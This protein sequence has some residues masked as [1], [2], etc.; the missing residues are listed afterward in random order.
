M[1]TNRPGFE[2]K[3][4][5]LE[6]LLCRLAEYAETQ[7]LDAVKALKTDNLELARRVDRFES[8]INSLRFEIEE[9][10]YRILALQQPIVTH[11]LRLVTAA[12][13]AATNLE[14]MADHAAGI[15]RLTIRLHDLNGNFY[16]PLF[17][18]MAQIAVKALRETVQAFT[19][20]DVELAKRVL[21]YDDEIDALHA[22]VY[23]M[24]VA[25]MQRDTSTIE[26]ATQLTW[27]SHNIER[28]A[29]RVSNIAER[30]MYVV[31]GEL[32]EVA[33]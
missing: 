25:Q 6:M 1:A 14:R 32:F 13:T 15:A 29:D 10:S 7:L 28:F 4:K 24:L 20:R 11:D 27:V 21:S 17:D 22:E 8:T 16:V 5:Q 3:L 2:R 30:V 23:K 26:Y 19:E 12:V 33:R 18:D 9:E 31:T